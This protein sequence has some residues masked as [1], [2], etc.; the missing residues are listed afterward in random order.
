MGKE[1][2][3]VPPNWEHPKDSNG[4]YRP[5]MAEG[6]EEAMSLWIKNHLLWLH[7]SHPDQLNGKGAQTE[8][9][10]QWVGDPPRIDLH[11]KYRSTDCTHYQVY[12]NTSEGAPI[13]PIFA[14][15]KLLAK[16]LVTVGDRA[17]TTHNYKYSKEEAR[18]FI[19]EGFQLTLG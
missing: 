4:N 8:Y 16:Y 18:K 11:P 13:T 10:A 9:Y 3:K 5:L 12:D 19:E 6:Y 7:G 1:I 14:T 2:R 15:L 17:G